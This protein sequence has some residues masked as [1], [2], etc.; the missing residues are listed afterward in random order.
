MPY[1]GIF[2]EFELNF[3]FTEFEILEIA[4]T[5]DDFEEKSCQRPRVR[6]AARLRARNL[7]V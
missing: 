6:A 1:T 3:E 2:R 5:R 4:S 7:P